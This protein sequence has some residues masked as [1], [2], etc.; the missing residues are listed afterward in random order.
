MR[1]SRR[2]V[3][4]ASPVGQVAKRAVFLLGAAWVASCMSTGVTTVKA[5]PSRAWDC[6]LDFYPDPSAVHRKYEDLCLIDANTGS[7]GWGNNSVH[8][9]IEQSRH[10]A[11]TC[12]ADAIVFVAGQGGSAG[13][14]TV[15]GIQYTDKAPSR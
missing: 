11:C 2:R 1:V 13:T 14:A 5:A 6:H 3:Q 9:A 10:A 8:D 4:F 7:A 12:G 15:R